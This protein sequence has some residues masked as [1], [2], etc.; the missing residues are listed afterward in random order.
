MPLLRYRTF[1]CAVA[2]SLIR[3]KEEAIAGGRA[4]RSTRAMADDPKKPIPSHLLPLL[5]G[6]LPERA[7]KALESV[8]GGQAEKV[9]TGRLGRAFSISRLAASTGSK[10]V[11]DRAKD[12]IGGGGRKDGDA[13]ART[14]L[15]IDIA[16]DMLR[17]F[18]EM[19]GITM[20][21][22]QMFSYLDD[23]LPPEARKVLAVLQR[24]VSPMPY[25]EVEKVIVAELGKRPDE[26]FTSFDRTAIAAASIGQVH[27]AVLPNGTEVAVKVQYPG[28][29]RAME[30]DLKNARIVSMF[31]HM[32]FFKTDTK[33]IMDEL[34]A[35]FID[36]C[37]YRKEADYQDEYR[38]RFAGH[39][40]IVVPEV[41]RDFSARRVLTTTFAHGRTFY[42]WLA[43]NPSEEDRAR[44]ARLFY[45]FYLGSFYMHGLFN[46]DPHPGNYLFR[47]DG[48]VV[49]L[50]YGCSRRFP[51]DRRLLWIEFCRSVYE[52][53][54]P[55][56]VRLGKEIGFFPDDGVEL[57]AFRGLMRYLYQPYLEDAPFD[58]RRHRPQDTFRRMFIE[59]PNL[60][61]LNMPADAVFLNRIGFGLVSLMSEIGASLNCH[62][63]AS[64]YFRG[65]DPDWP[66][67]PA[68]VAS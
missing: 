56:M 51:D 34:E 15:G 6:K 36:E 20:K 40:W 23:A 17:T 68:R 65:V 25:D 45:R 35:R 9:K 2:R 41:H 10:L 47:D 3:Q 57:P 24:D 16:A 44:V 55:E 7:A 27:R 22:G 21:L 67:E 48:R 63:Y 29:D 19:R 8:L 58:F 60:F 5:S 38:G 13:A 64:S 54:M 12:L 11:L 49:F 42:Q 66:E 62:R 39:P 1:R 59:N 53:N 14:E 50:D 26:L 32:F 4:R 18:S 33:A 30:A 43:G 46:C 61:K 37:D 52:D 31:K 28:I